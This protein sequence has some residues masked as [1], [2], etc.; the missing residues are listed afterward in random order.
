[1]TDNQQKHYEELVEKTIK[2]DISGRVTTRWDGI[3]TKID[4]AMSR[5]QDEAKTKALERGLFTSSH[6]GYGIIA[7]EVAE[8]LDAIRNNDAKE[9]VREAI[10]VGASGMLLAATL[11]LSDKACLNDQ[12]KTDEEDISE[13]VDMLA[14]INIYIPP[15]E[16]ALWTQEERDQV[17]DYAGAMHLAAS[18][19]ETVVPKAPD[20]LQEI[21]I[22]PKGE[23]EGL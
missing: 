18:D 13:V 19:N 14:L 1:M 17:S 12:E 5:V 22:R 20:V 8:L 6:E 2:D 16:V 15:R 23:R 3:E 10:Q 7:E 21:L 4:L 11:I 9:I